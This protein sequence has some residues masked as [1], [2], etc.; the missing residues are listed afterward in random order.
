MSAAKTNILH[1]Y[2]ALLRE[3]PPR[4]LLTT[5]RAPLHQRLRD[6]VSSAA[7]PASAGAST[8]VHQPSV[9]EAEQLLA[10]LQ[11]QREYVTLLERYNP[12]MGMDEET[13]VRLTAKRVGMD[14]PKE[15]QEG[16]EDK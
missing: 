11:A 16:E 5:P 6:F 14:L 3:L 13:R 1:L 12:G 7:S 4:P 8:P 2:R 9:A 10:Y 15:F